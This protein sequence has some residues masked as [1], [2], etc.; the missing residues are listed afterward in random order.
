MCV[1]VRVCARSVF[2]IVFCKKTHQYDFG[3]DS[4]TSMRSA[5]ADRTGRNNHSESWKLGLLAGEAAVKATA[6]SRHSNDQHACR[7]LS[8]V[9][10]RLSYSKG[11]TFDQ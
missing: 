9:T 1:Y 2:L 6:N 10:G 5:G 8:D 11:E 3:R 7:A 4:H